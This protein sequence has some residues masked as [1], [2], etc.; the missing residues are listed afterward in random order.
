MGLRDYLRSDS[1]QS[2]MRLMGFMCTLA[3]CIFSVEAGAAMILCV[4]LA[5]DGSVAGAI[6][7]G[8][9][10]VIGALLVPAFGGKA[11]QAFAESNTPPEGGGGTQK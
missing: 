11:V 8:S 2:A 10:A 5:R 7:G 9:A 6:L 4:V 3:A 1:N